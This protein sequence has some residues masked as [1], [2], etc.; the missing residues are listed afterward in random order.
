MIATMIS[1]RLA[2]WSLVLL[3]AAALTGTV[4]LTTSHAKLV[5]KETEIDLGTIEPNQKIDFSVKLV[6][7]GI[8]RLNILKVVTS[9]GC[10]RAEVIPAPHGWNLKMQLD[11]EGESGRRS[12]RAWV[13][14]DEEAGGKHEVILVYNVVSKVKIT[15]RVLDFGLVE[16]D[17]WAV[18]K[19]LFEV[20]GEGLPP[21]VSLRDPA[22]D[23][24]LR[25]THLPEPG[26]FSITFSGPPPGGPLSA[27]LAI[28][29]DGRVGKPMEYPIRGVV[30][31]PV[32]AEPQEI[33]ASWNPSNP[34]PILNAELLSVS[35]GMEAC[36]VVRVSGD[37]SGDRVRWTIKEHGEAQVLE[38]RIVPGVS[39][40]D[41]KV[42][43]GL[44]E[45]S[46][47]RDRIHVPV[48]LNLIE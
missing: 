26:R 7:Q 9:C 17:R 36:R 42:A 10:T 6:K 14:T 15:P 40:G 24:V 8:G 19:I 33:L 31:G 46:S 41:V 45:V 1:R 28:A 48:I 25:L 12:S 27:V 20:Q 44:V 29:Q 30:L 16:A 13:E 2:S 32:Y 38:G 39:W 21:R 23:S 4:V 37:V 43:R 34:P 3:G 35:G 5:V 22:H 11:T 18:P 47:G